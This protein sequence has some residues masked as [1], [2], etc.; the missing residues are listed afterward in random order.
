MGVSMKMY[1]L[2][3]TTLSHT[4][5][6]STILQ[7]CS[8][9]S[10]DVCL[11][12][13][14]GH[15]VYTNKLL[16]VINSNMMAELMVDNLREE[17][18]RISVPISSNTLINLVKILS[19]GVTNSDIRFNPMEVL[20]AAEVLGITPL[21]LQIGKENYPDEH[22]IVDMGSN[23]MYT[24]RT[25]IVEK[26][27]FE[28]QAT[29]GNNIMKG[30]MADSDEVLDERRHMVITSI[31]GNLD[32]NFLCEVCESTFKTRTGL[33][34]HMLTHTDEKPFKCD[35]CEKSFNQKGHL[36]RHTSLHTGLL[37]FECD[38]CGKKCNR[39][40]NLKKHRRIHMK[41]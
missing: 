41:A 30:R 22:K 3:N 14:E 18:I 37:P 26:T 33:S 20:A 38:H 23:L 13:R 4:N 6:L 12:T 31:E 40:D 9:A 27:T 34:L 11:I 10:P 25:E 28:D 35:R 36:E 29:M 8:L 15:T 19:H 16:L 32:R 17:L 21:D 1:K 39:I 5:Y 2:H 24:T 7:T